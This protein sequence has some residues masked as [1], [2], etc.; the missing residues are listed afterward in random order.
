MEYTQERDRDF[1]NAYRRE[2][3]PAGAGGG[4]GRSRAGMAWGN[5]GGGPGL[6]LITP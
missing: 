5:Q 4:P 6:A 1:M 3:R 2:M